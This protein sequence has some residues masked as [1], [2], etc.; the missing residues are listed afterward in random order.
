MTILYQQSVSTGALAQSPRQLRA[1]KVIPTASGPANLITIPSTSAGKNARLEVYS[2]NGGSD[3]GTERPLNLLAVSN[4]AV[5]VVGPTAFTFPA[6]ANMISGTEYWINYITEQSGN[7]AGMNAA[8][9]A[10]R[11]TGL[12]LTAFSDPSPNPWTGT[13]AAASVAGLPAMT[14]ESTQVSITSVDALFS[15]ETFGLTVSSTSYAAQSVSFTG[16]GVTKVAALSGSAGVFAGIAP[17]LV[18]G[19]T[20]LLDGTISA[21]ATNGSEPTTSTNTTYTPRGV[22]PDGVGGEFNFSAVTLTSTSDPGFFGAAFGLSPMPEIGDRVYYDSTITNGEARFV[23]DSNGVIASN[24]T[25]ISQFY[26]RKA[27]DMICR[28]L[29]IETVEGVPVEVKY[30]LTV[31]GLSSRGLSVRGLTVRGL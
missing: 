12:T 13:S 1:W 4:V 22:H 15:G 27:S 16:G 21:V 3:G 2:D 30:G 11:V 8:V 29:V 18:D 31:I 5:T 19:Q 17:P 20:M 14:I 6:P 28:S 7:W 23:V 25:G 24:Y 10:F 26:V 9:S